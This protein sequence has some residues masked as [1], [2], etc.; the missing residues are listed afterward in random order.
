MKLVGQPGAWARYRLLTVSSPDSFHRWQAT[1]FELSAAP[2]HL[3]WRPTL[4]ADQED[5]AVEAN[6]SAVEAHVSV[7]N[8]HA[9]VANDPVTF[10]VLQ[11][12]SEHLPTVQV[13]ILLKQVVEA[14]ITTRR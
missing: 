9:N 11:D 3:N 6:H 4:W 5:L 8:G 1:L 2:L 14:A 13:E 10:L 7:L 12:Q